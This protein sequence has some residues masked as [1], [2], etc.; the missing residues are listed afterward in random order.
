MPTEVKTAA[1]PRYTLIKHVR[2]IDPALR[3]TRNC[4][5]LLVRTSQRSPLTVAAVG[6]DLTPPSDAPVTRIS[7]S[8]LYACRSFVDLHMH[9][10]EPGAMYKEDIRTA[11]AAAAS[12]GYGDLLALPSIP[13][14]WNEEETV[15]YIRSNAAAGGK[16]P[17]HAAAYL[18]A[19]NRGEEIAH[20][21]SLL[22][23]GVSAF[24]EEGNASPALLYT[25]MERLAKADA[26]LILRPDLR[27]YSNGSAAKASA[28]SEAAAV[29]SALTMAE[30][31]GCRLHLTLITTALSADLIRAAKARGMRVTCDTAPQYFTLT[32]TDLL[33]YGN[34]AKVEPPLR[35]A[36]DREAIIEALADGT[37]DCI[38]S[39]HTPETAS[40]KRKPSSEAPAGMIGLQT[41]FAL[42]MRELVLPGKL[43]LYRLIELLS[44]APAR[45]LGLPDTIAPGVPAKVTLL[46]LDREYTLTE[47]MLDSKSK[48]CPWVGQ[49][50][51]GT[52]KRN[53]SRIGEK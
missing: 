8:G 9:T 30:A 23:H 53:F 28:A 7:G 49:S 33:Y 38:V 47:G 39:D 3:D 42:G 13:S 12:G 5:I 48:N 17:L 1:Y 6:N 24:Y 10:C 29:A 16:I 19:G 50:F 35:S 32:R 21:D 26:L 51:Q 18:T 25:A 43:D 2:L 45:V 27:L 44:A 52:V 40:D 36:A 41:A 11:T 20:T 37:V 22:S 31:T 15:D 46:D 4:D 34:L 14:A